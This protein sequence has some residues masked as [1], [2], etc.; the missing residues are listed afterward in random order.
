MERSGIELAWLG[1]KARSEMERSGIEVTGEGESP[2]Y[3]C[4]KSVVEIFGI[5]QKYRTIFEL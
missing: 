1:A 4:G 2:V 5:F 3:A